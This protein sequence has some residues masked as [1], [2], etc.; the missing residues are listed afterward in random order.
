M[1]KS[2]ALLP[3]LM[4]CACQAQEKRVVPLLPAFPAPPVDTARPI[5]PAMLPD[6]KCLQETGQPC[7]GAGSSSGLSNMT[8]LDRK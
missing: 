1:R 5:P 8:R 2:L 4:L 6:L 3:A 7:R